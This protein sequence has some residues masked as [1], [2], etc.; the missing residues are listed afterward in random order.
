MTMHK[1][2]SCEWTPSVHVA[3]VTAARPQIRLRLLRALMALG[4]HPNFYRSCVRLGYF[5]DDFVQH[6]VR[7]PHRRSPLINRGGCARGAPVWVVACPRRL[8]ESWGW[9]VSTAWARGQGLQVTHDS[10][11]T[12]AAGYY[13]RYAAIRDLLL[14]F[15]VAGAAEGHPLAGAKQV[16][17]QGRALK[18]PGPKRLRPSPSSCTRVDPQ[19]CSAFQPRGGT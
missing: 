6:F 12:P 19:G 11:V 15:L 5:K 14:H 4:A 16:Q 18:L 8:K 10:P 13:S 17:P 7:R 2:A 1:S 3:R 9:L